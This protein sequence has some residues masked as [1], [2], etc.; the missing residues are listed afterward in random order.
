MK[1]AY[2]T[3]GAGGMYCG[4]CMKDNTLAAALNELGHECL[5]VLCYT[6]LRLDEA[7]AA[8]TPIFLSGLTMYLQEKYSWFRRIPRFLAKFF[9]QPWLLRKVAGSAVKIE[10][11][12]LAPMTLS[13]LRGTD[14]HQ[15]AEV[16]RLADW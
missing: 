2:I 3:A 12:Q 13:L 16:E 9:S 8:H 10:A 15:K 11:S 4:S 1:I 7:E 5:L 14:G 6:P